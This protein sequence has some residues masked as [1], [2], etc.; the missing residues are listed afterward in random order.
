MV[1]KMLDQKCHTKIIGA[2]PGRRLDLKGDL[3]F[4]DGGGGGW[5]T[6]FH[7]SK[8]CWGK[9][10]IEYKKKFFY[11]WYEILKS[12]LNVLLP[13]TNGAL[14]LCKYEVWRKKVLFS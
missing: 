13:D 3:K 14:W 11:V 6:R 2:G 1:P 5:V 10:F 9:S 8:T 7:I 12:Q 4:R